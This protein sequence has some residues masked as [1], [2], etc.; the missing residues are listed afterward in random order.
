LRL[1]APPLQPGVVGSFLGMGCMVPQPFTTEGNRLYPEFWAITDGL[2][3]PGYITLI[4]APEPFVERVAGAG[5]SMVDGTCTH[6]VLWEL[7]W[8]STACRAKASTILNGNP[9]VVSTV[10]P[11]GYV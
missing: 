6:M 2:Q 3:Y 9:M 10:Y 8:D 1:V 5:H 7:L 4:V 11:R